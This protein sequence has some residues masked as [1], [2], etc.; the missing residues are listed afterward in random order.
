M[1]F[2]VLLY[3]FDLVLEINDYFINFIQFL[4]YEITYKHVYFLLNTDFS[5]LCTLINNALLFTKYP[6]I[7]VSHYVSK[8]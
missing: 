8:I 6:L 7:A 3:I 5:P 1:N 2:S 4:I